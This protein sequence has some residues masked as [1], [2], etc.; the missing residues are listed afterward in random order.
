MKLSICKLTNLLSPIHHPNGIGDMS[1]KNFIYIFIFYVQPFFH[2]SVLELNWNLP[3]P[4][5]NPLPV[6]LSLK[7]K[8]FFFFSLAFKSQKLIPQMKI[9][10]MVEMQCSERQ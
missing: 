4:Y 2:F 8:T 5:L 9:L 6:G 7:G 3:H 10:P 1:R